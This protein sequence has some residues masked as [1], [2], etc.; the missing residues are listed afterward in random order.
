MF[1]RSYL[2]S[3]PP[4]KL[5]HD[6]IQ[7]LVVLLARGIVGVWRRRAIRRGRRRR[8]VA[9]RRVQ[10]LLKQVARGIAE[11]VAAA[12][13][14]RAVASIAR[15]E[16][17]VAHLLQLGVGRI[18]IV[19]DAGDI[20]INLWARPRPNDRY[21]NAEAHRVACASLALG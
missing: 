9:A 7:R 19:E 2:R 8:V 11:R 5:L 13:I 18:G 4:E 10:S 17:A 15:R 12:R 14:A 6:V 20:G 16:Q 1:E 21:G 3:L